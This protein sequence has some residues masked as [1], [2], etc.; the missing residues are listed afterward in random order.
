MHHPDPDDDDQ[1]ESHDAPLKAAATI[2]ALAMFGLVPD[3]AEPATP[4]GGDDG[5]HPAPAATPR[6]PVGLRAVH[7][8]PCNLPTY[9]LWCRVQTQ[10]RVGGMGGKTGLD[11]TGVESA[12]RQIGI[13]AKDRSACFDGLQ[14]MEVAALNV[15]ALQQ[16]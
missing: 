10:W 2:E 7:V 3:D 5:D 6:G 4:D 9:N 15:W 13:K 11:Y 14:T 8:W 1:D 12:M 16:Q